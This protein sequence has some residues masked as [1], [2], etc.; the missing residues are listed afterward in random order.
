[1]TFH[2]TSNVLANP[3]QTPEHLLSSSLTADSALSD[4]TQ[5]QHQWSKGD[6]Q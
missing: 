2:G 3:S 4:F 5:C 6:Y 1:M